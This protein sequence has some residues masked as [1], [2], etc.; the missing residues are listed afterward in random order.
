MGLLDPAATEAMIRK[1]QKRGKNIQFAALPYRIHKGKT[2]VLLITSRGTRQWLLPKGWP[3]DGLKPHKTAAQEAWEEAGILGRARKYCLGTYRY[4]KTRGAKRGQAIRV[5]VYPLE[6]DKLARIYP[7]AGQRERKW[8]SP[9]K[10]AKRI[11]H[12]DLA[13]LVRSFDPD[14]IRAKP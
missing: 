12:P 11:Y 14:M 6:V 1:A 2:E 8:L 5:L 10:A 4:R 7:E 3:M 13:Q 9:K